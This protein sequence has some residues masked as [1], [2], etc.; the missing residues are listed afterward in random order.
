MYTSFCSSARARWPAALHK[1]E[2]LANVEETP[3]DTSDSDPICLKA[4]MNENGVVNRKES[5]VCVV[6]HPLET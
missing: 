4:E 5:I 3:R 1:A 2:T 6:E